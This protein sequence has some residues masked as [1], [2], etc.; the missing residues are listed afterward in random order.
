M[1][2]PMRFACKDAGKGR[3][4]DA[5][6]SYLSTYSGL[7]KPVAAPT[8]LYIRGAI[9]ENIREAAVAGSFYPADP[10]ELQSLLDT[11]LA[12]AGDG[13]PPP[14][15]M[16]LPHAGYIYSGPVA[17]SGYAR[18]IGN[19]DRISR[20]ILLGPTHR[21]AVRGLAL[22]DATA[23]STPLGTI[24]LDT[25]A[26][27]QI[28]QLPQ[29]SIDVAAHRSEHSL[30]VHLPFLQRTLKD[31]T[32]VPILVGDATASEV[33]EVIEQLW[34]G[35]E[36][37]LIVSSD[38]SH[39]HDYATASRLDAATSKAIEAL[40][41]E[42]IDHHDACGRTPVSGLLLYARQ[43]GLGIKTIDLRNSGDTAGPR[44]QVV[45]YGAYVLSE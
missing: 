19:A 17:A 41:L 2:R 16:I 1:S 23:F 3:E 31:F 8:F 27:R 43:H 6:A 15:A 5:E 37:L 44:D 33:C 32:L 26:L 24:P 42:D 20:V 35:E 21:K 30:E 7:K 45:G 4:Q 9:M 12:A 14:K 22:P 28:R 13:N 25:E 40:A 34:G 10:I 39:Y 38:L 29:V 36:T 18:L 11:L